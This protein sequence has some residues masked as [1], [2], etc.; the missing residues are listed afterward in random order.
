[1]IP[2]DKLALRVP[3]NPKTQK[4]GLPDFSD[5]HFLAGDD[6]ASMPK[7]SAW[8]SGNDELAFGEA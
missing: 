7:V 2:H 5:N 1:V 6:E 8:E 4:H 3:R